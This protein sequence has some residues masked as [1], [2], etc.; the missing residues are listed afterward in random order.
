MDKVNV[1]LAYWKKNKKRM[2]SIYY[3]AAGYMVDDFVATYKD[4]RH[5]GD[6]SL[7]DVAS[8]LGFGVFEKTRDEI[9]R[10]YQ[11]PKGLLK[12]KAEEARSKKQY[13]ENVQRITKYKEKHPQVCADRGNKNE[14]F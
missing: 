7:V 2:T 11:D 3:E 14:E 12:K 5:E 13:Q 9:L 4:A 8:G 6:W 10:K 1:Y